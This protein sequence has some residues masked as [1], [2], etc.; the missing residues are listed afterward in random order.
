V[1][2]GGEY[3]LKVSSQALWA[4]GGVYRRLDI[5]SSVASSSG[6]HWAA[7]LAWAWDVTR[8]RL[9]PA[10]GGYLSCGLL[11]FAWRGANIEHIWYRRG[12]A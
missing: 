2:A 5:A 4:V 3:L 12:I 1:S 10:S 6:G 7:A 8:G 11:S 9:R